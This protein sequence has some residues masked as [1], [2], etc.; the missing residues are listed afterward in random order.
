MRPG[1]T[2]PTG[3][4]GGYLPAAKRTKDSFRRQRRK[5]R[6]TV[7]TR[8]TGPGPGGP[9]AERGPSAISVCT[10]MPA[11]WPRSPGL[12]GVRGYVQGQVVRKYQACLT[13]GK[14][15]DRSHKD[16]TGLW[17]WAAGWGPPAPGG[18]CGE[19][20]CGPSPAEPG[21]A[22]RLGGAGS[23]PTTSRQGPSWLHLTLN[24]HS[25]LNFRFLR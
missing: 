1:E 22:V 20:Q 12:H 8:P 7:K 5:F 3:L 21:H 2:R 10:A 15:E 16:G 19:Q 25:C 23:V 18:E 14:K 17:V 24:N 6:R 11:C 9:A 13:Q 4:L